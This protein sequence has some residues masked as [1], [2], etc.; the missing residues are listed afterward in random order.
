MPMG[1]SAGRATRGRWCGT[2]LLRAAIRF[3]CRQAFVDSVAFRSS[4]RRLWWRRDPFTS[5]NIVTRKALALGLVG[6]ADATGPEETTT[7]NAVRTM[8]ARER[9]R[10]YWVSTLASHP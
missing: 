5:W 2:T 10:M 6:P 8:M 3:E 7:A 9:F 4:A 1:Y